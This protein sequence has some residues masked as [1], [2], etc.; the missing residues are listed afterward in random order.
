MGKG[1]LIDR[2]TKAS[3][4]HTGQRTR[5]LLYSAAGLSLPSSG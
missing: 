3:E 5:T 1:G 2:D 4:C